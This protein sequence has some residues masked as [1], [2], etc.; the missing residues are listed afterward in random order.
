MLGRWC[1]TM[2]CW[3]DLGLIGP[4][5]AIC[6]WPICSAAQESPRSVETVRQEPAWH[7]VEA[8]DAMSCSIEGKHA[9]QVYPRSVGRQS[10]FL[11]EGSRLT[12][13]T[14]AQAVYLRLPT[15]FATPGP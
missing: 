13:S 15:V 10:V 7:T 14:K 12:V 6:F 4:L 8:A 2:P 3:C 11:F 9:I 5:W 1:K